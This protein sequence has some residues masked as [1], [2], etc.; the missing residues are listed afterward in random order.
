NVSSNLREAPLS[1]TA[2]PTAPVSTL[3]REATQEAHSRA[4]TSPFVTD[5]M[6]GRLSIVAFTALAAQHQAIY[7]ALEDLGRRIADQPG[8]AALVRPELE[9][10]AALAEDLGALTGEGQL[11]P[12]LAATERY[13]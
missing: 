2:P 12:I 7:T 11:P 10:S 8:A 5:L 3:L 4:E 13:T 9:R 6:S 1:V